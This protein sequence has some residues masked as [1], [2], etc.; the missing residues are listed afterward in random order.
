MSEL[1]TYAPSPEFVSRAHVQGMNAYRKLY[2]SAERRPAEFWGD[3]A[4][5]ELFW[6]E[7]WSSVFEWQPPFVRWFVDGKTNV[8]YNCIDR[9]L[10][11]PRKNKVAI[12]W[13]GEP[14]DQRMISY[15]ELHRLVCRFANVLKSRGFKKGDRAI[16][17]MPMIPELPVALLAC[18]RL[19][20]IHSVVFGGFSAE[21]LKTRIQ[22]ME[23]ELVI[24][25][26]GGWR[27]GKEVKLKPTVDEALAECP[28]IRDVIVY[29][30]T[31]SAVPMQ[32]GRDLWWHDLDEGMS[33][34]CPAEP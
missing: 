18:A 30:R 7:K 33:E 12:L 11:T 20:I 2:E 34:I 32:A 9:H 28:T 13:E 15:Q 29:R 25:A 26:D 8:S 21:A 1:R 17:Y 22:D 4:E 3:L 31:G 5:R 14:G 10:E 16:V 23:A 6:F 24:T 27:R 19:G